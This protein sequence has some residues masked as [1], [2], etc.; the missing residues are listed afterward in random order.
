MIVFI[1]PKYIEGIGNAASIKDESGERT[2]KTSLSSAIRKVFEE[3]TVDLK[4][5]KK[6]TSRFFDQ[7][8]L[9]PLY[10]SNQEVLIPVRVRKPLVLKDGGYGYVNSNLIKTIDTEKL[11][12]KDGSTLEYYDSKDCIIKR[13]R[14]AKKLLDMLY[15]NDDL[16]VLKKMD[17]SLPATKEDIILL[18]KEIM[19][20]KNKFEDMI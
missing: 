9:V 14:M 17:M 18:L 15:K 4:A 5:I 11:I 1:I 6:R 7:K 19:S 16:G 12:L 8:Y 13:I 3:R 2:L 10:L 20:L